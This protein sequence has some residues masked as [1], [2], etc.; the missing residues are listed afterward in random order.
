[1]TGKKSGDTLN[2]LAHVLSHQSSGSK[3]DIK[4]T[5][6]LLLPIYRCIFPYCPTRLLPRF[7]KHQVL[8]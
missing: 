2:T 1:M 8:S 4:Q 6:R 3:F 5:L 7:F